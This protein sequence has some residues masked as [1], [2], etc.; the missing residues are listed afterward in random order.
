MLSDSRRVLRGELMVGFVMLILRL[1]QCPS[2]DLQHGLQLADLA[3]ERLL[4]GL[5][6]DAVGFF[7]LCPRLSLCV[8]RPLELDNRG[9]H[10][11]GILLG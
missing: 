11:L 3:L 5:V 9:V 7:F 4:I 6:R 1:L 2:T 8:K 10:C